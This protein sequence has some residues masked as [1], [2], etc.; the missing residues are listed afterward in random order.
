MEK[1]RSMLSG[2]RLGQ[3]F[4]VVVVDTALVDKTL[5]EVWPGQKPS[6][7]H[8]RIFG[9]EAFMHV[10]KEKMSKLDNKEENVFLSVIKM[11]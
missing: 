6:I 1:A 3:E 5:H 11:E 8:L 7:A 2:A 10:P 4:Q 9:C